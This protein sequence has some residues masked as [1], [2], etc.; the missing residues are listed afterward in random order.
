VDDLAPHPP[1]PTSAARQRRSRE[2]RH[3]LSVESERA[4]R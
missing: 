4:R 3:Q 2:A 1:Q